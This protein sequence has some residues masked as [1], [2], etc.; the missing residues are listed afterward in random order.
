MKVKIPILTREEKDVLVLASVHPSR[1]YLSNA[2]IGRH[3]NISET[4][5]KTLIHQACVKLKAHNRLEA[6]FFALLRREIKLNDVY[7]I[8]EIAEIFRAMCPDMFEKIIKLVSEEIE[9]DYPL[10]ED[11]QILNADSDDNRQDRILTNSERDVIILTARGLTNKEIAEK[12]FLSECSV[13]TFLYRAYAKLGAHKRAEAIL[14]AMKQG[15]VRLG[16]IYTIHEMLQPIAP[17]GARS[18]K[19]IAQLI[20][21]KLEQEPVPQEPVPISS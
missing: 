11:E 2:E 18:L 21:K 14:L 15:E 17:L 10:E 7:T 12:L 4:R 19:N 5:V 6:V 20:N 13:R 16:D 3:L 8:D 1:Q 9:C